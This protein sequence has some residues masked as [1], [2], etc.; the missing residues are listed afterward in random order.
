MA[1]DNVERSSERQLDYFP[2]PI[3][4]A[5]HRSRPSDQG[6]PPLVS[7]RAHHGT[8]ELGCLGRMEQPAHGKDMCQRLFVQLAH[9][10]MRGFYRGGIRSRSDDDWS[11]TFHC[12][13]VRTLF[14]PDGPLWFFVRRPQ[15]AARRAQRRTS[16]ELRQISNLRGRPCPATPTG[17]ESAHLR[18]ERA[19]RSVGSPQLWT[20]SS[21]A[22]QPFRWPHR[23]PARH[24]SARASRLDL[25]W[26]RCHP[27]FP[28]VRIR[29]S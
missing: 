21:S 14:E 9:R 11:P 8:V 4:P 29:T 10:L 18:S 16:C 3:R 25:G 6:S 24:G 22:D 5:P 15:L 26:H 17:N 1:R 7:E 12:R 28:A 27:H 23:A 13:Q 2:R 20:N 19:A